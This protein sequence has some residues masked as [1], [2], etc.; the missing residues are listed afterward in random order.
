MHKLTVFF[1][2]ML[3]LQVAIRAWLAERQ[4]A[5]VQAHRGTVPPAFAEA[6]P[7]ADHMRAAD[8]TAS[9]L[10]FGRLELAVE[11]LLLLAITLGGG[12]NRIDQGL[13]HWHLPILWH[14][15]A[16]LIA[17]T[18][19]MSII[20]LP[21]SAY[22]TF[23][24][25]AHFGFNR[26]TLRLFVTDTVHA[27]LLTLALGIPLLAALL[28]LMGAMGSLWWLYAWGVWVAFT[29]TISFAWPR[30][31][32]PLFNQFKPLEPGALHDV[33]EAVMQRCGF[34][35]DGVFI[36]DG[37]RRSAHGNAYFTGI[38]RHKRIVLFDTLVERLTPPEVEAVL[39]HELGHFRLHHVRTRLFVTFALALVGFALLGYAAGQAEFYTAFGVSAQSTSA[40][41]ALFALVIPVFT[42]VLGPIASYFSR[43]DEYAADRFAVS[44]SSGAALAT[45]LVKLYRDNAST[46]TPDAWYSAWNNSHPPATDR[47]RALANHA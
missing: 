39:A 45:A 27:A 6:V 47:I 4:L 1:L 13:G 22:A 20:G 33:V 8:Y 34:A 9:K 16:C 17:L 41:L 24:I 29:L 21:L 32:A 7:L 30:F 28:A 43:R 18:F 31:I 46:L 19:A 10:R 15:V 26:T 23:K 2:I 35:A 3:G 44:H 42:F 5:A 12:F 14:G 40:A 36:M 25:E 38:G 37:S 11:T